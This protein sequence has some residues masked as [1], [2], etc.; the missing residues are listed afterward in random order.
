LSL[1]L[2]PE[3]EPM[4]D[5]SIN[6]QLSIEKNILDR[7]A[8]I[9]FVM[10]LAAH[11]LLRVMNSN[12]EDVRMLL[13]ETINAGA[14]TVLIDFTQLPSATYEVKLVVETDKSIDKETYTIQL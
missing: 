12:D 10:P 5:T 2:Y 14:H 4:Q 3:E 13:N 8:K 6:Y 7:K 9:N 11:V 1:H